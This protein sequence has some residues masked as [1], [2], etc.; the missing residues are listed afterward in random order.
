MR[1][2][3]GRSWLAYLKPVSRDR[4]VVADKRPLGCSGPPQRFQDPGRPG[5]L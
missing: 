5:H 2:L 4:L 1:D 3:M